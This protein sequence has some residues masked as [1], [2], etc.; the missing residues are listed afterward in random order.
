[1]GTV[2]YVNEIKRYGYKV[3]DQVFSKEYVALIK[4]HINEYSKNNYD[5]TIFEK[6][7]KTVRGLHGLHLNDPFFE[8]I[9][10][11]KVLLNIVMDYLG[12][13][14]Y[15]HQFKVNVKKKMVGQSW[16]WHED[17]IYWKDKDGIVNPNLLNVG[18]YLDDVEMLSGPLCVIPKSHRSNDL[19]NLIKQTNDWESD[20]S[21][22]LTYQIGFDK[23]EPLIEKYGVD[24]MTGKAGDVMIF[25]PLL[26][27]CSSVNLSPKDRMLM[28]ITY[29]VVSNPAKN[30]E[31][32]RRPEFLCAYDTTALTP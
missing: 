2:E 19:T 32:N 8:S 17:F 1:M 14:C 6:D 10:R 18:I 7:G 3:I 23:I 4:K 11:N 30:E 27:H 5:G 24:Y 22:E 26:A 16:P 25:D 31:N 13:P 29:N 15:V 12:E 9:C 21:K 28:I 20:L